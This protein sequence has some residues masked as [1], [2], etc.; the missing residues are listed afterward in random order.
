MENAKHT[1]NQVKIILETLVN[2]IKDKVYYADG[3][4]FKAINQA[5]QEF[6]IRDFKFKN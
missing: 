3:D 2:D 5:Y 6:D 1:D 4:V